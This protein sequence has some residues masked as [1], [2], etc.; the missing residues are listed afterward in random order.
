MVFR[1]IKP[2][3]TF[4]ML[5]QIPLIFF[6]KKVKVFNYLVFFSL[7]LNYFILFLQYKGTNFGN[8]FFWFGLILGMPMI[9]NIYIKAMHA[10]NS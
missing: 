8:C 7:K 3:L 2:F 9:S 6:E 4:F 5:M 10:L 1:F